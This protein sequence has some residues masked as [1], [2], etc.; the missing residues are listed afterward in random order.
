MIICSDPS[1]LQQSPKAHDPPELCTAP[2]PPEDPRS[3]FISHSLQVYFLMLSLIPSVKEFHFSCEVRLL[4]GIGLLFTHV[5]L[6]VFNS[7]V[8][9]WGKPKDWYAHLIPKSS[10]LGMGPW[11]AMPFKRKWSKEGILCFCWAIASGGSGAGQLWVFVCLFC[12]VGFFEK[13][14]V[15]VIQV[16]FELVMYPWVDSTLDSSP[17]SVLKLQLCAIMARSRWDLRN[18]LEMNSRAEDLTSHSNSYR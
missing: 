14:H 6:L 16:G 15:Y 18:R 13:R 11:Q 2:P 3:L 17:A 12:F 10:G 8:L 1:F 7:I 5:A 9:Y 4:L